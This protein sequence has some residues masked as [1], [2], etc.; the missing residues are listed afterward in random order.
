MPE[1]DEDRAYHAHDIDWAREQMEADTDQ[2]L[3][4]EQ[5]EQRLREHGPNELESVGARSAWAILVQQFKSVVIIVLVIAAIPAVLTARWPEAIAIA[6]VVLVNT[7]LGFFS[8][9]KA[10][11]TIQSLK[12]Q[13]AAEAPVL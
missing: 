11:R 5:A 13:E 9:W 1:R 3:S 8:E 10:S 6:A 12:V 2:G 4:R 7:A